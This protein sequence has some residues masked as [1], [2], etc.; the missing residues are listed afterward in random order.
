MGAVN[1]DDHK[2]V[3]GRYGV[4]GFPTIK[5]IYQSKT[6]DYNGPRTAQGLADAVVNAIKKKINEK[7]GGG[8]VC[9]R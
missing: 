1:A 8:K 6:E 5:I 7:L 4:R 9:K 2:S 3:A